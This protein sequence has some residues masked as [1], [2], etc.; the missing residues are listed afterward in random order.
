MTWRVLAAGALIGTSTLA[1]AGPTGCIIIPIADIL[2]H[3]EV[4]YGYSLGGTERNI[5]KSIWHSHCLT[6]G[7][8]DRIEVGFDNDFLGTTTYNAKILLWET[9]ETGQMALSAGIQN[10]DGSSYSEPYLVGRYDLPFCRVHVG[11]LRDDRWR[12]IAGVDF[13]IFGDWTGAID[14]RSGPGSQIWAGF[15]APIPGI[16]GLSLDVYGGFP[17]ERSE[18]IQYSIGVTYFFRF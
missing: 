5:D 3:R 17:I 1:M 18:G 10:W 15:S 14:F 11:A 16:D 6:I 9:P 8:F 2:R 12:L 7:L 13:P 4:T